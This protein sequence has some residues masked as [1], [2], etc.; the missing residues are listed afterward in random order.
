[1]RS[2]LPYWS[3]VVQTLGTTNNFFCG[4]N[5]MVL[6]GLIRRVVHELEKG[7]KEYPVFGFW[8]RTWHLQKSLQ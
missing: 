1:M 5:V 3:K 7:T 4:T 6:M 8:V 2:P